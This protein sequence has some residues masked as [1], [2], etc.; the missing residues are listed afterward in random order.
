MKINSFICVLLAACSATAVLAETAKPEEVTPHITTLALF[1]NGYAYV[2]LSFAPREGQNSY[3]L[4]DMPVATHGT[5]WVGTNGASLPAFV[6][7][8]KAMVEKQKERYTMIELA[9]ANPGEVT[10][11]TTTK[12]NVF[13]GKIELLPVPEKTTIPPAPPYYANNNMNIFPGGQDF[14]CLNTDHGKAIIP[15]QEVAAIEF[16]GLKDFKFPTYK[17]EEPVIQM[18]MARVDPKDAVRITSVTPGITWAPS[19]QMDISEKSQ[20]IFQAK[21]E[22]INELADIQH[23]EMELISG[24]PSIKFPSAASPITMRMSMAEFFNSLNSGN[25][26][27]RDYG[28]M[29]NVAAQGY[30]MSEYEVSSSRLTPVSPNETVRAEDLFFYPVKDVT[31]AKGETIS[32]PLFEGRVSYEHIMT[33]DIPDSETRRNQTRN[34]ENP[35]ENPNEV[36]HCIRLTNGF[37]TPLTTAPIQF[38]S[39]GRFVGQSTITFTAEGQKNTVRLNKAMDIAASDTELILSEEEIEVRR[40]RRTKTGMQG[41][42]AVHNQTPETITMTVTKNIVGTYQSSSDEGKLISNTPRYNYYNPLSVIK[43]EISIPAGERKE[44]TYNYTYIV[45]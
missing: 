35:L 8:T 12:G 41:T 27:G 20:G 21:A 43:W 10:R 4:K 3:I 6:S 11:L 23:A 37:K 22:I 5:F 30:A 26:R 45:E 14:L 34:N 38:V 19:Y 16:P 2:T 32:V 42:L 36:W 44:I 1:K 39:K 24:F 18:Q 29:S 7:G 33:W 15:G 40:S 31:C 25:T 17:V 9:Q 13:V 28:V